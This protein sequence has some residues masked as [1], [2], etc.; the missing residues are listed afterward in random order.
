MSVK[1]TGERAGAKQ[2]GFNPAWQRHSFAYAAAAKQLEGDRILDLG[3]GSGHSFH[4]FDPRTTVGVDISEEALAGQDRETVVAD[5]RSVPLPDQGFDAVFCSHAIEHVPDPERVVE[6]ARRLVA[7]DGEVLFV[8]PNR[9][10]FGRPDEIIDPFHFIEFSPD[11]FER[12]CR[13]G[14]DE[15]RLEGLFASPRYMKLFDQERHTLDRLLRLDPLRLR[16][17]VPLK[18]KQWLYDFLL[19]HFRKEVDPQAEAIDQSDFELRSD[20]LDEALD[21]YAFCRR[22]NG[23]VA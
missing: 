12:I 1:E 6:E 20:R 21:L 13:T 14:F 15:V 18:L 8:T 22:P 11:E 10:T 9:L 7:A 17:L 4:L 19:N 5:I 16:R 23:A 2:G 3:C